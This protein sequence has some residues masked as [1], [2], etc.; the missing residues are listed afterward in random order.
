MQLTN[1]PTVKKKKKPRAAQH[2]PA[3][4]NFETGFLKTEAPLMHISAVSM[5][6]LESHF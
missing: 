5:S 1:G 4:C 6:V 2:L 3:N